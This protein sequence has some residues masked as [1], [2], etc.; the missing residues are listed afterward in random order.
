[1][2]SD[3]SGGATGLI[4]A[5]DA[6]Q[7]T[8]DGSSIGDDV[9]LADGSAPADG[10]GGMEGSDLADSPTRTCPS[11]CAQ[12]N[13]NCGAVADTFCGGVVQCGACTTGVCGGAAPSTCGCPTGQ[14]ACAAGC[15]NPMTDSANCGRC[16][17]SCAA[18]SVQGEACVAGVCGCPAGTQLCAGQQATYCNLVYKSCF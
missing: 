11:T 9:S 5:S 7:A 10:S 12:L 2:V 8:H 17:T 18:T 1:V 3:A 15:V 16:G 6:E 4:D 14:L 13:A